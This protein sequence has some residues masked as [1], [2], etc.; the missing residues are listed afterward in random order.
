[1]FAL[2]SE[3]TDRE[4]LV[5]FIVR[6]TNTKREMGYKAC[7]VFIAAAITFFPIF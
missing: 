7:I 1:M 2:K 5:T 4:A 6:N 3:L